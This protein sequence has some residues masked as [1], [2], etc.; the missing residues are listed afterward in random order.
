MPP[1]LRDDLSSGDAQKELDK[2]IDGL[3]LDQSRGERT[4]REVMVMATDAEE[5][6]RAFR[7]RAPL[8]ASTFFPEVLQAVADQAKQGDVQ[9]ARLLMDMLG[10]LSKSQSQINNAIQINVPDRE[11]NVLRKDLEEDLTSR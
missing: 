7:Q 11:L 5:Y 4:M 9:A 3:L 1:S 10:L 6:M 8:V 2:F